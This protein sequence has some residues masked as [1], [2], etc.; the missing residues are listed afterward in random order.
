MHPSNKVIL[1]E[2]NEVPHKVLDFFCRLKPNSYVSKLC[3]NAYKFET[4]SE[5]ETHLSPWKT[6]PSLHRGVNDTKHGILEFGQDTSAQ[7]IN[8]PPIWDILKKHGVNVGVFGSL[9]SY[10]SFPEDLN[11]LSFYIPDTFAAG[12]ECFPKHIDVFQD[13]NL[14]MVKKSARNVSKGILWHQAMAVLMHSQKLG[15]TLGTFGRIGG[16][17]LSERFKKHRSIRRR[18]LQSLIAFDVFMKQLESTK[19]SFVTFFTNHVASTMHRYWAACFPEDYN[20]FGYA[21]SWVD[22]YRHEIEYTMGVFDF[23]LGRL[24]NFVQ[25]NPD[26]QLWATSSMGQAA[27]IAEPCET[28]LYMEDPNRFMSALGLSSDQWERVPAMLPEYNFRISPSA[29]PILTKNCSQF[30]ILDKPLKYGF[31]KDDFVIF[32]LGHENVHKEHNI[33]SYKGEIL[34]LKEIGLKIEKI[35]DM[36]NTNAYHIPS[37]HLLIYSP[38]FKAPKTKSLT[39][40]STL[41]IA[42]ALLNNFGVQRPDYMTSTAFEKALA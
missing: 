35:E 13:F 36:S 32:A 19:P 27:T 15:I 6:W 20:S 31:I 4:I 33:I 5:D 17:L 3:K 10:Q 7:D 37:G 14:S 23:M 1:F 12:S 40:I 21:H 18:T 34:S 2:L 26:Y 8:F 25:R 41:E 16:Q 28:Q 11:N 24:M 22:K 38:K 29:K 9:H 30:L 39:Q 42:P